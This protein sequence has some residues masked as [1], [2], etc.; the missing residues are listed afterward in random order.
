MEGAD[1]QSISL[2]YCKGR[3]CQTGPQFH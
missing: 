2:L 1:G 3:A